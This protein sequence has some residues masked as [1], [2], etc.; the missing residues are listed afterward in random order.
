MDVYQVMNEKKWHQLAAAWK[1]PE[2]LAYGDEGG[3][4]VEGGRRAH[5]DGSSPELLLA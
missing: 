2:L 4:G 3:A 1:E 5:F